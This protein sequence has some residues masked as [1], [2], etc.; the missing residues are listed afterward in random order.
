MASSS[1]K[2]TLTTIAD[3]TS[4]I[5]NDEIGNIYSLI[6][7]GVSVNISNNSI[8][9]IKLA[10]NANPAV[11]FGELF[12]DGA[13]LGASDFIHVSN[14]GLSETIT[15]GTV[16]I[17]DSS[18]T[19]KKLQRISFSGNTTHT[20][21]DNSTNYLDIDVDG[22][23]YVTQ[24]ST[25][26]TTRMR[27]LKVVTS[28]GSV[29]STTDEADR[30]FRANIGPKDYVTGLSCTIDSTIAATI[31][32]GIS[33]RDTTD[34]FNITTTADIV[35]HITNS[36]G[37]LGLDQGSES[38]SKWYALVLIASSIGTV[39]ESALIVEEANY[40]GSIVLPS[41]YDIYRRVMWMRND[42]SSNL[43]VGYQFND[44]LRF[45]EEN[46]VLSG[47]STTSWTDTN[48]LTFSCPGSRIGIFNVESS[49]VGDGAARNSTLFW[50][51]AGKS[52]STGGI[53]VLSSGT[54]EETFD[55][56]SSS[57]YFE[58]VLDT[59]SNRKVAFRYAGN[60]SAD[61]SNLIGYYDTL[62]D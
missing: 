25:S 46:G 21:L 45:F 6:N 39:A 41:S 18:G 5:W 42:G 61:S 54:G 24:S 44:K 53:Q 11:Y 59:T 37:A 43:L 1:Q 26:A 52:G 60:A 36:V 34:N 10:D 20:V 58:C 27:L 13:V 19:I 48:T 51:E 30:V 16:Y 8:T 40:P 29:S 31:T 7:G 28:G 17:F 55:D 23:I 49:E 9:Q 50:A 12:Q 22:T 47:F 62:K 2:N 32:S 35:V 33:V 14:T 57:A 56:G 15:G 4:V 38:A 3:F